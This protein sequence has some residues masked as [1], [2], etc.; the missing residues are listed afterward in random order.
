MRPGAAKAFVLT[1]SAVAFALIAVKAMGQSLPF[2]PYGGGWRYLETENFRVLYHPGAEPLARRTASMAEMVHHRLSN[3]LGWRPKGRTRLI[4]LDNTDQANAFSLAF[5]RNT[6]VVHPAPPTGEPTNYLD[7]LHEL[8]LHEY[9]HTLHV[10]MVTGFMAGLRSV[11]GR[12][13]IPNAV[14]PMNQLEGLAVYAESRFTSLGRNN[15]ALTGGMLRTMA[16]DGDWPGI[17]RAGVFNSRWPWDAPYLFGGKFTEFLADSFGEGSLALYNLSHGGQ[18]VPFLQNRP[19]KKAYGVSLDSLWRIWSG[20]TARSCREQADSLGVSVS[21][22]L[23]PRTYDGYYKSSL[24]VSPGGKAAAFY[25]ND[26]RGHPAIVKMD[27]NTGRICKIHEGFIDGRISFSAD[28]RTIYFGQVDYADDGREVSCDI[29]SLSLEGGRP[30]RLTR[31]WRARDPSPSPDGCY[32]YFATTRLGQG[33]LCRLRLGGASVDTLVGF[34]DSSAVS[35]PDVSPDGRTLAFSAWTGDG[36]QD[37]YLYD[38][39]TGHCRPITL[40]R[41]QDIQPRWAEDGASLYFSSD[42]SGVWNIYLWRPTEA[43]LIR[44]TDQA[45]G[46]FWPS[47][48]DGGI[49]GI[50]LTG[51]GYEVGWAGADGSSGTNWRDYRDEYLEAVPIPAFDGHSQSYRFWRSMLP[52]AWLPVAFQD[53]SG[54]LP[55]A[56]AAGADDLMRHYYL[57]ALAPG[58]GLKRLHYDVQYRCSELPL[59][60]AGRFCDL[61]ELVRAGDGDDHRRRRATEVGISKTMASY[62][63]QAYVNLVYGLRKHHRATGT[64]SLAPSF[65]IGSLGEVSATFAYSDAR[66]FPMSVSPEG[67]RSIALKARLYRHGL[68]GEVEQ[69]WLQAAWTEYLPSP[70][71][72]R[73]LAVSVRAG[74]AASPGLA[75]DEFQDDFRPRGFDRGPA[76]DA[77]LWSSLE[78]RLPLFRPERGPGTWPVFLHSVHGA[79]FLDAGWGGGSAA[80]LA[81]NG[82]DRS[83]GAE[84]RSDW[85]VFYGVGLRAGAGMALPIGGRHDLAPY[86]SLSTNLGILHGIEFP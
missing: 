39:E 51:K 46:A 56:M 52:V 6:I 70:W 61:T 54:V 78:A 77:K 12:I 75:L 37:I 48:A 5:P 69:T 55:G 74:R 83:L 84:L 58:S 66:L 73:V 15:S 17:D 50:T 67:G 23:M 24:S 16:S 85:T 30:S 86:I 36:Y 20:R 9:T 43:G 35:C 4:M 47:P 57:A 38:L 62:R 8:L 27:V 40:D 33:A 25:R 42:R 65:W 3:T 18:A 29:Y 13:V 26:G 64:D 63:R 79:F 32:L 11:F 10:D 7:W 34:E 19:A 41:A 82:M 80:D 53:A 21:P 45:G 59:D 72:N 49:W 76:G 60:V 44:C 28:G 71:P 81:W 22:R 2:V 14:Q 1:L 31:G 68:G